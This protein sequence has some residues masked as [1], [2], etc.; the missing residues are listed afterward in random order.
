MKLKKIVAAVLAIIMLLALAA[1]GEVGQSG[2]DSSSEA[3]SESDALAKAR[4]YIK[5]GI[6]QQLFI[7][8][9]MPSGAKSMSNIDAGSASCIGQNDDGSYEILVKGNFFANDE[10]GNLYG[11]YTFECVVTV[12]SNGNAYLDTTSITVRKA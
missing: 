7:N 9:A 12:N 11:H 5:S 4:S 8:Q 6:G 2:G 1:C 10:Y 3:I